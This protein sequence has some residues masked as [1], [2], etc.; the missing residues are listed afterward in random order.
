MNR[1]TLAAG[2]GLAAAVAA[3]AP[4]HADEQGFIDQVRGSGMPVF[5]QNG[6]MLWHGYMACKK[7][8]D[9]VPID[10]IKESY[11]L[12]NNFRTEKWADQIMNITQRELCPDTL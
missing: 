11:K 12:I 7:L 10:E 9:G 5:T 3:A 4:A 8:R 6:P 2:I 1:L